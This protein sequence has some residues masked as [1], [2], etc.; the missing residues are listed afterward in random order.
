MYYPIEV[1]SSGNVQ[2]VGG[3]VL[4]GRCQPVYSLGEHIGYDKHELEIH[5]PTQLT[6]RYYDR[7]PRLIPS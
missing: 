2:S 7:Y 6:Y 3:H 4:V 1:I 5:P